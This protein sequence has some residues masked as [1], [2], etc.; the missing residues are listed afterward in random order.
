MMQKHDWFV[1]YDITVFFSI[2]LVGANPSSKQKRKYEINVI[3]VD[4]NPLKYAWHHKSNM[5]QS[6]SSDNLGFS[7]RCDHSPLNIQYH[8]GQTTPSWASLWDFFL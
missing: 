8:M 3:L 7:F 1:W 2:I 4:E 6:S 5:E